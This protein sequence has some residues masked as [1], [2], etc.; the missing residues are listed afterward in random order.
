MKSTSFQ[1]LLV[2]LVGSSF[3]IASFTNSAPPS[4]NKI[5]PKKMVYDGKTGLGQWYVCDK[6][7]TTIYEK[8][9]KMIAYINKSS[10]ECFGLYF[11]PMDV[12]RSTHL[13]FS[14]GLETNV[15]DDSVALYISFFD[16]A[17]NTSNFRKLKVNLGK[18]NLKNYTIALDDL[19]IKELKMDFSKINSILFYVE[20]KKENGFWGNI[21]IKD[22]SFH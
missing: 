18:G 22:I 10:F 5:Q 20:S 17:K 21:V 3:F 13:N 1:F 14:A 7:K 4:A 12:H 9:K 19:I 15:K 2:L 16:V 11:D 8:D 6:F